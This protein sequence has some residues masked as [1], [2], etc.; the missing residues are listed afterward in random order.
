[1]LNVGLK[2]KFPLLTGG[3]GAEYDP[4]VQTRLI[5]DRG[6]AIVGDLRRRAETKWGGSHNVPDELDSAFQ[7]ADEQLLTERDAATEGS[8]REPDLPANLIITDEPQL[9]SEVDRLRAEAELRLAVAPPLCALA[10]VLAVNSCCWWLLLIPAAVALFL[11]ALRKRADSRQLVIDAMSTDRISSPAIA[12]F[13]N[14]VESLGAIRD[15]CHA[16]VAAAEHARRN[17]AVG[18]GARMPA[19]RSQTRA[20][21][22]LGV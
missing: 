9:Y 8:G 20:H 11:Q 2:F 7:L 4:T 10:V 16:A 21:K 18:V 12:R 14:W 6:D 5:Y 17:R 15:V 1:L 13:S 3:Y 22:R 19:G